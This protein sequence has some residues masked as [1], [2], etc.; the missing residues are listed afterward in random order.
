MK[1][2]ELVSLILRQC[3]DISHNASTD[4]AMALASMPA[5]RQFIVWFLFAGQITRTLD[6][7]ILAASFDGPNDGNIDALHVDHETRRVHVGQFKFHQAKPTAA[8]NNDVHG[9]LASI[10]EFLGANASRAD[11]TSLS[12]RTQSDL[13]EVQ[14][15]ISSSGYGVQLFFVTTGTISEAVSRSLKSRS[16]RLSLRSGKPTVRAVKGQDLAS[17]TRDYEASVQGY[18]GEVSLKIEQPPLR[19]SS[20][21]SIQMWSV[22][23]RGNEVGRLLKDLGPRIFDRNIRGYLG[24]KKS[25]TVNNRMAETLTTT[26]ELFLYFNNGVTIICDHAEA[27]DN[28]SQRVLMIRPQI[29]NGQQ[30][31]NVL[32]QNL[33][34]A[35]RALVQVR[36]IQIES[37]F[38]VGG[39]NFE[40]AISSIVRATN[41][42]TP[43]DLGDL[44]SNDKVQVGL[45]RELR[46]LQFAYSRKKGGLGRL[47]ST[48]PTRRRISRENLVRAVAN[49]T[50]YALGQREGKD[51]Y[52]DELYA[53]LFGNTEEPKDFQVHLAQHLLASRAKKN[54]KASKRPNPLA[55]L[56]TFDTWSDLSHEVRRRP[57]ELITALSPGLE[58]TDTMN[59]LFVKHEVVADVAMRMFRKEVTAAARQ[60]E[61]LTASNF[62]RRHDTYE[63]FRSAWATAPAR[64]I[65][66]HERALE[67]LLNSIDA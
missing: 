47:D 44:R 42:Q 62:F 5:E 4:Q 33:K 17:M 51:I 20:K 29:I 9:L 1:H 54:V 50:E 56:I 22:F 43:I 14:R 7:A 25:E 64:Q 27:S 36:V 48:V 46:A 58:N 11:L 55:L 23:A 63:K 24:S 30:T 53:K 13:L 39:L 2:N 45:E 66:R 31:T 65:S 19:H 28:P 6:D 16:T 49:S 37:D 38:Q 40:E 12:E 59:A 57:L 26:P 52:S 60:E 3:E 34:D 32:S 67:N 41:S 18:A 35:E 10:D 8:S 61:D 15:L 21:T